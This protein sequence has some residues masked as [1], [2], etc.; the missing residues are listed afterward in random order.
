MSEH[1]IRH[2]DLQTPENGVAYFGP[3]SAEEVGERVNDAYADLLA[4]SGNVD[5][6]D[7]REVFGTDSP[8]NGADPAS[9]T[10]V[11]PRAYWMTQLAELSDDEEAG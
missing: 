5:V 4:G 11:N 3:F 2:E 10:Y 9:W 8:D 1:Y 6:V 7:Q